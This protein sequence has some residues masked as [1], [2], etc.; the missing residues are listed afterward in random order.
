MLLNIKSRSIFVLLIAAALVAAGG[1]A[2]KT[3]TDEWLTVKTA[4]FKL[5]VQSDDQKSADKFGA[6]F[7]PVYESYA[8]EFNYKPTTPTPLAVKLF[9]TVSEYQKYVNNSNSGGFYNQ[10][11]KELSTFYDGNQNFNQ[12]IQHEL[13]H[14]FQDLLFPNISMFGIAP[15][16]GEGM[17]AYY[18]SSKIEK[19]GPKPVIDKKRQPIIIAAIKDNS[20]APLRKFFFWP[21]DQFMV[22]EFG[23]RRYAQ[24]WSVYYFLKK[25]ANPKYKEILPNYINQFKKGEGWMKVQ[26]AVFK[27]IDM[28]KLESDWKDYTTK[29]K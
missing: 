13:V 15:W 23:A 1:N 9:R 27:D 21:Q 20:Y 25:T 6:N 8:K 22:P 7:E 19:G 14:Y 29:L 11:T 3:K 18:E 17:A 24:A 4:H 28:D 10:Q 2:A 26:E 5:S 12:T 16:F